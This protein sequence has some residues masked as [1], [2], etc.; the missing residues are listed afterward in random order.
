MSAT[1]IRIVCPLAGTVGH[2]GADGNGY[3]AGGAAYHATR[4]VEMAGVIG[5]EAPVIVGR[6]PATIE[7]AIEAARAKHAAKSAPVASSAAGEAV[8]F[9]RNTDGTFSPIA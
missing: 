8:L 9:R 6:G 4:C 2:N 5:V 7:A 1:P 3:T